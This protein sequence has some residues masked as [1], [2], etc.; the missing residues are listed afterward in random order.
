[1]VGMETEEGYDNI[2][3]EVLRKIAENNLFVELEK[4]VW[5]NREAG[6]LGVVIGLDGVKI[7]KEKV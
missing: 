5:K 1:M 4:Y 7:E 6:I 2:V 3:E